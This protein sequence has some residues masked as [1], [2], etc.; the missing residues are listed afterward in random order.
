MRWVAGHR[1]DWLSH[2]AFG[3]MDVGTAVAGV[4]VCS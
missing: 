4:A 2:V 1:A 3:V